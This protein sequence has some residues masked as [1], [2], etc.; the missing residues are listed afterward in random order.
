MKL[1]EYADRDMMMLDLAD[2]EEAAIS[3]FGSHEMAMAIMTRCR[4]PPEN[5]C[6]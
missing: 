1:I 2:T 4:M 6:G 3:S 5:S